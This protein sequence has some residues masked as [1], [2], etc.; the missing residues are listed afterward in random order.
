MKN[1]YRKAKQFVADHEEAFTIGAIVAFVAA[2]SAVTVYA[3][4]EEAKQQQ[5]VNEWTREQ[6]FQGRAVY[7]LADGSYLAVSKESETN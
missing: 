6:N 7:Q 4:N 5:K 2:T 3:V 1:A